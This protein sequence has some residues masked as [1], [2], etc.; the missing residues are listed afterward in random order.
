MRR[1][2]Y[3]MRVCKAY[4]RIGF[5][6]LV[7]YPA[8]T[9]IWILSMLLREASGFIGIITI[10]SV[11]G[12]LGKWGI[13]EICILFS[14]CAIIEAIGQAFLDCVWSI[15]S[16]IRKGKLDVILVRPASP[17]VQLLGQRVHFQ[18]VITMVIYIGILAY[19]MRQFGISGGV[20]TIL[21][22]LET[23]ICGTIINT[24]LYT[25]F[26]SLNFWIV[27]GND[28][29]ELVLTCREFAKYPL[30]VFPMMIRTFFTYMIPFGFMGYYPVAF[31]TGKTGAWVIWA[32]PLAA[33][34]VVSVAGLLWKA[35]LRGYNSTGT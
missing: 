35:G 16:S 8:D 23:I 24:G 2:L 12:G 28:V 34:G 22:L 4:L 30:S 13:Y 3:Y 5:V 10:A 26:N 7:Q 27:N 17:F 11:A 31:L 6:T 20:G 14:I 9:V 15:S 1:V 19:S 29:A 21:F 32:M 33:F 18:A 25:I